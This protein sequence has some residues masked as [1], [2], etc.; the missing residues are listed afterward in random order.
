MVPT[1]SST[2]SSDIPLLSENSGSSFIS[3]PGASE[4]GGRTLIVGTPAGQSAVSPLHGA[5]PDSDSPPEHPVSIRT[6]KVATTSVVIARV[7][8]K[9]M[10][11]PSTSMSAF[12]STYVTAPRRH[13][14]NPVSS[15]PENSSSIRASHAGKP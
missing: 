3:V 15:L 14:R 11:P 5:F 12:V 2:L 6:A 8:V 4:P 1:A 9:A 10:S 13:P 7:C